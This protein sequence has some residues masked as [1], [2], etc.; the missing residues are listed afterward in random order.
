MYW[1]SKLAKV[2]MDQANAFLTT[3]TVLEVYSKRKCTNIGKLEDW[4]YVKA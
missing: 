4:I 2:A 1:P 3:R